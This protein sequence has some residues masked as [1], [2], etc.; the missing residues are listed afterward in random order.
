MVQCSSH[1]GS[2]FA[3]TPDSGV[4]PHL[5]D[6]VTMSNQHVPTLYEWLGGIDALTRLTTRFYEYVKVDSLLGPVFAHMAQII[7][8]TSPLF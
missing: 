5:N 4:R 6:Q 1:V 3:Y 7:R 2:L 8:F